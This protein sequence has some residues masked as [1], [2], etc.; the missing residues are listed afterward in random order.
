MAMIAANV[1]HRE[2]HCKE[3]YFEYICAVTGPV[4]E[5]EN[6]AMEQRRSPN[7]AVVCVQTVSFCVFAGFAKIILS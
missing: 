7:N 4:V 3:I 6:K 2:A 5:R 1:W